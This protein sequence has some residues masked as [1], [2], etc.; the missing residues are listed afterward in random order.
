MRK[1]IYKAIKERLTRLIIDENNDIIVVSEQTI[2]ELQ[3]EGKTP[4]YAI[5]HCGLWN[6]QVEFIEEENIF[7][8]PAVFIEFGKCEWREQAGGKQDTAL[9]ISLHILTEAVPEGYDGDLFHLDLIEGV[10]KLLHGF[11][12][13]AMSSMQRVASLPCH[14]HAEILDSTEIFSCAGYDTSACKKLVS[15]KPNPDINMD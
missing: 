7:N 10:N 9:T 14:D 12:C 15:V 5:K 3:Q 6:R 1:Q 4:N 11:Q 13:E 2:E 8:M